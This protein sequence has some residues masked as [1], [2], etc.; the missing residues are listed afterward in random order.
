MSEQT[1]NNYQQFVQMLNSELEG[2]KDKA[3]MLAAY[4]GYYYPHPMWSK[5]IPALKEC[6]LTIKL[7]KYK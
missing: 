2:L 3:E 1:T 4:Y 5:I 7:E 6:I